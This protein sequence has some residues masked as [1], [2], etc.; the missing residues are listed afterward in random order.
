MTSQAHYFCSARIIFGWGCLD[1]LTNLAFPRV[2]VVTDRTSMEPL[3]FLERALTYLKQAGAKTEVLP[4]VEGEPELGTVLS[5]L[6]AVRAFAPDAIVALGGGSVIDVAKALRILYD[7]PNAH[8]EDYLTWFDLPWTERRTKLVAI[9]STSGTG[10]ET[11]IVAVFTDPKQK[12]KRLMMSRDLQADIAIVDPEIPSHMPPKLTAW[13]GMDCLAQAIES[14]VTTWATPFTQAMGLQAIRLAFE[15][16]RSACREST[17]E[18]R[19]R[20]HYAS[21]ISALSMTNSNAGLGHAMDQVGPQ[22]NLHHGLTVAILLPYTIEFNWQ[23][24]IGRAHV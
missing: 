20:M 10:S 14:L 24:E 8:I 19:E 18:S 5:R 1:Q 3:G 17:R 11:T 22:F 12:V 7:H 15:N 4:S 16:L 21:T 9:P 6:D 23:Q 13:T 2:A